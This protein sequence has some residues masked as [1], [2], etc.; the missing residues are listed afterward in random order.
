MYQ[1]KELTIEQNLLKKQILMKM[2]QNLNYENMSIKWMDFLD[3]LIDLY[4]MKLLK[5]HEVMKT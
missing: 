1:N 4:Q 5:N 2:P 3:V